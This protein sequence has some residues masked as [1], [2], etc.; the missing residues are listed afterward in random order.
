MF[1]LKDRNSTYYARYFFSQQKIAQGFPKELRFSL[2]TKTRVIAIDRLVIVI[3]YIRNH[4]ATCKDSDN[5][6]CIIKDLKIELSRIRKNNFSITTCIETASAKSTS[7]TNEPPSVKHSPS[8]LSILDDF[9]HSKESENILPRSI[10]QLESRIKAFIKF[11]KVHIFEATSKS[12]MKFRDV[13]LRSGKAEKSVIEYLAAI[14]QFYKWLCLREDVHKNIFDGVSVQRKKV[15]ASELRQRWSRLKLTKLFQHRRL[16]L[17]KQGREYTQNEWED[18]WIPQLLLY[19]GAR[20]SEICQLD[21][22]DIKLVNGTWCIDINDDGT[23]KRLK[24]VSAKRLIPLHSQLVELGFLRYAQTRYEN[25][26]QKLFSFTP[27]GANK[28][29]SKAYI[30]RFSQILDELGYVPSFRPTLHSFRHTFID[31]LQQVGVAENIVADLVGHT[32]STITY[33]RYGKRVELKK[34]TKTIN[35]IRL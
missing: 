24:S 5:S 6:Q 23:D 32:K 14:R 12:A 13:L 17:P 26:Q 18:Y 7:P 29:W 31:E 9:I 2:D 25:K 3:A 4:I 27:M 10:Q 33:G 15:R 28:D 34:L 22:A 1:L 30:T 16:T 19:S 21:T 35:R 11:S 20:V 8:S